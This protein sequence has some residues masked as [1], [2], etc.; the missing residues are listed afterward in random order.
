GHAGTDWV[1]G[2]A[3]RRRLLVRELRGHDAGDDRSIVA[4]VQ[5]EGQLPTESADAADR[6][7]IQRREA[8]LDDGRGWTAETAAVDDLPAP[9]GSNV[10][11]RAAERAEQ[12]AA[13]GCDLWIRR[14]SHALHRA[15]GFAGRAVR[16]SGRRRRQGQS[17]QHRIEQQPQLRTERVGAG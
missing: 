2:G 7:A 15:A 13:P 9:A 5:L 8:S 12:Q 11:G 14:L 6:L 17:D 16:L 1:R 10:E 4:T 3:Q